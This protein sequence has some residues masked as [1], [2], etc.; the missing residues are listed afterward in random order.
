MNVEMHHYLVPLEVLQDKMLQYYKNVWERLKVTKDN[1]HCYY[2]SKEDFYQKS[3]WY[4]LIVCANHFC[5]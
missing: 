4:I 2:M 3:G 1:V 5:L